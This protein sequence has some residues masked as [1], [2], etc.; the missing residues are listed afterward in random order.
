MRYWPKMRTSRAAIR[1]HNRGRQLHEYQTNALSI[2]D[3]VSGQS[4]SIVPRL[5]WSKH[6]ESN[7]DLFLTQNSC[8][9]FVIIHAGARKALRQWGIVKFAALADWLIESHQYQ[10][11]WIGSLDEHEVVK[12]IQSLMKHQTFNC[13]GQ[14]SL[15]ETAYL[16][17]KAKLYVGNESG[18]L[19]M[20]A[21][22]QLPMVALF[23]PGVPNVFYPQHANAR[24]LHMILPC[25]PCDQIHC[26][27]PD[28]PCI[29][30]IELAA[31]KQAVSELI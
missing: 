11:I 25:N 28:N 1:W 21:S 20:A 3:L 5:F 17:S 16:M 31:V 7:V 24:V 18:P 13:A 6:D 22:F 30:R 10:V 29:Q 9:P 2:A 4:I 27:F 26:Q 14:W 8:Q 23:G 12:Q 19:Q 15:S